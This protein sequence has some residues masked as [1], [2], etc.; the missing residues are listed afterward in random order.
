MG[1]APTVVYQQGRDRSAASR[2]VVYEGGVILGW[3]LCGDHV[4]DEAAGGGDD[5]EGEVAAFAGQPFFVLLCEHGADQADRGGAVGE[6][7]DDVSAASDLAVEPLERVRAPDLLRHRLGVGGEAEQVR[8]GVLEQVSR[9][10]EALRELGTDALVL[11]VDLVVVGLGEDRP[12]QG[13]DRGLGLLGHAGEQVAHEVGAAPLPRRFPAAC[14]GSRPRGRD[15]RLRWTSCTPDR[16]R[17]TRPRRKPSHEAPSSWV[18]MSRP[19]LSRYPS[20]LT[21]VAWQTQTFTIRPPSLTLTTSA[22]TIRY[23]YGP[24]SSGR[25][26]KPSTISSSSPAKRLWTCP[27]CRAGAPPCPPGEC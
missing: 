16:P 23:G 20:V 15:T 25:V 13:G 11:L 14:F 8:L 12:H 10:G 17:A 5:V 21:A 7:A 26:R 6:D 22:S 19:R 9:G 4:D 2:Q 1:T 27:G 24:M 3:W 18:T